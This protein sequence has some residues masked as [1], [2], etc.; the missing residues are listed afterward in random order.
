MSLNKMESNL[1]RIISMCDGKTRAGL[2]DLAASTLGELGRLRVD[3]Y[4]I[5]QENNRLQV[6]IS[7]F[8]QDHL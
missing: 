2:C 4:E 7:N 3:V 8:K 1:K 5:E 6:E